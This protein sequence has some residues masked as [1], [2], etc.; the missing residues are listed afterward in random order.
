VTSAPASPAT[1][2]STSGGP[3]DPGAPA[4]GDTI[5]ETPKDAGPPRR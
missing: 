4:M 1:A 2:W 5:E 3:A